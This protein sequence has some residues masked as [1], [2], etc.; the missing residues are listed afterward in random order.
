[1]DQTSDLPGGGTGP[2]LGYAQVDASGTGQGV[3]AELAVH[4]AHRRRG[5]G[6]ALVEASRRESPD[7]QLRIWAHGEHPGAAA[8]AEQLGF[9]RDRVLWQLRRSLRIPIPSAD[10]PPGVRVRSFVTGQDEQA[11]VEVNNRAFAT[12]PDQGG[13][14]LD[15]LLV[16]ELEPWFDPAGFLLAE[17]EAD[18]TL[19]GFHWTK[20]HRAGS[21]QSQAP[22]DEDP[23]GE[24]LV[25]EVYVLGID[26]SAQGMGLG[27]VLT[28]AGLRHLRAAGLSQAMLYVD[29]S[30]PGATALYKKLG[31]T[32]WST[33]ISYRLR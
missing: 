1:M 33:D 17:R 21:R 18:G 9:E 6:R 24:D 27:R 10:P 7:G 30:N 29:E 2:V 25:G 14:D 15:A 23:T 31:F 22:T 5:I 11:W 26:P 3:G 16:R 13:W 19:L 20:V 4:P 28:V 32:R 8:L 12:H